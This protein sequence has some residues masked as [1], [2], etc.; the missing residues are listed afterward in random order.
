MD[1]ENTLEEVVEPDNDLKNIL[2]EY[3]GEKF[4]P[5]DKLISV[6]MIVQVMADEFP[7]VVLAIAEENWTRGYHQALNDVEMG[8]KLFQEEL[9]NQNNE[10]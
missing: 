8:E 4:N 2:V 3:T 5:S 6:E 9:E 7:E 10:G 1:T